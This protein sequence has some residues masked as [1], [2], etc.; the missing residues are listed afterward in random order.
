MSG[1]IAP[2]L[3]A[4]AAELGAAENTLLGYGRDLA[5]AETWLAGQGRD[6]PT[7][8]RADIEA[9][10]VHCSDQGLAAATRARRLSAIRQLYRFAF[11]EGWRTDN[12]AIEIKGP[13]RARRL[14]K[15]LS[16]DEVDRLLDAAE[17]HGR[18]DTDRLRNR[19][20]MQVLYATGMRVSELVSLP[21]S[22][23]R[24]D[25][26]M[27]LVLGK[28]GKER[29]VPLLPA[30]R[31]AILDYR[32]LCPLE[33]ERSEPVFRGEK[34]GPLNPRIVQR[35]MAELRGALGLPTSATPHALRHSF[36]THLLAA[37]GDLR[38]IQDLLGHASL[39]STQVY[40]KVET[41][42]LLDVYRDAHPRA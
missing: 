42:R 31:D 26:R 9:Y 25:P 36:A 29:I 14:P 7:A 27:L 11:E 40:T 3:E 22:A 4:Q 8:A 21:A 15:T 41:S 20:L 5:D 28:G 16:H 18:N 33:P 13:G 2:F 17:K 23:A 38:A 19:C 35:R 34:G 32:Q 1:W 24:G 39:S 12:P 6:F 10:L 37:G 30:I